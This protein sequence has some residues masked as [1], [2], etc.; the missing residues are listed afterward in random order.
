MRKYLALLT[1]FVL[2]LCMLVPAATAE[3]A[4]DPDAIIYVSSTADPT[5]LDP[6]LCSD[7]QSTVVTALLFSSLIGYNLDGSIYMDVAESYDVSEDGL[8]YT[9]HI[10]DGIL[11]TDGTSCDA[12]AIEWN[13]NRVIPANATADMPYSQTLFGSVASFDAVDSQTFVV[14]LSKKDSTFIT[15]QGSNSLAAGLV[16]PTAYE[17]D[18]EGFDRNP[19]G[20]GP[21]K[22]QEWVSGQ[23]VSLVRNDDYYGGKAVN[24]GVVIRIIPEAS[25][26]VSELMVGGIDYLG[27]LAADQIDLLASASNV[28]VIPTNSTNLSILSFADYDQNPLF[29]DIRLRQAVCYALDMESINKALFG[30]A[31]ENAVSAIP[32]SMQAGADDYTIIGYDPDMA[33][34]LMTE[35][36]YPDGF[37]FTLL[38]Y[39]VVKGYNP[40]GEQLAVQMQAELAKVGI[41]MNIEILP[42]AEFLEKMY[43]DPVE[44]YDV[45]LHGWGADYND[46]SN[47]LMLF[48]DDEVGGGHNNSGYTSA[49]Y[50][51][52]Y[53][54]AI[55]SSS[56]EEAGEFYHQA[57]QILN[58]DCP[59]YILGHGLGYMG[60]G[61][62][63]I[64]PEECLGGWGN[65]TKD[66]M[67]IAQ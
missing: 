43:G 37:E 33:K 7:G 11:F 46:T 14:T 58:D 49:A 23:Y 5:H 54:A 50:N 19:V 27:D 8:T 3:A 16:S 52:C 48:I 4:Y 1:G 44:G 12:E 2:V 17:A 65:H 29:S 51:E 35:A 61:A 9:F 64:N 22:F 10:R 21:Y 53:D 67:K 28:K 66:L 55:T 38:T 30:D 42:W 34:E 63:L 57:A 20:C 62:T 6:A 41:T 31:M 25:T 32:T 36:G 18:P 40:A 45:I 15:L 60:V 13:W 59:V 24:G 39:N 26:S 56:Y 47:I